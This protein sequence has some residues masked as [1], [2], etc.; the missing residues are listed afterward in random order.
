MA[1]LVF[2]AHSRSP[3]SDD[4]RD[5]LRD[6]LAVLEDKTQIRLFV[7]VQNLETGGLWH[8]EIGRALEEASVYV[9]LA[10]VE[11][12]A[13][14]SYF[15][16]NEWAAIRRRVEGG[17]AKVIWCAVNVPLGE[18][19][20]SLPKLAEY[21][22]AMPTPLWEWNRSSSI[23]EDIREFADALT[24]EVRINAQAVRIDSQKKQE[25]SSSA[26]P[27]GLGAKSRALDARSQ[28]DMSRAYRDYL[29]A[30]LQYEQTPMAGRGETKSLELRKL[31]VSLV[32]D[33]TTVDERKKAKQLETLQQ[34]AAKP[35]DGS[36][37]DLLKPVDSTAVERIRQMRESAAPPPER[38]T[39]ANSANGRAHEEADGESLHDILRRE[40]CCVILGDPGSGKSVLCKWLTLELLRCRSAELDNSD[41][42]GPVR[43]PFL[44]VLRDFEAKMEKQEV[45][46]LTG[47]LKTEQRPPRIRRDDWAAFVDHTFESGCAFL[48]L[49]GLD[50][51]SGTAKMNV[52]RLVEDLSYEWIESR[53][54]AEGRPDS[55][56]GNQMV[57]TSRIT[58]YYQ[59]ALHTERFAHYLIRPMSKVQIT[60][61]CH[62][63]CRES[64]KEKAID[65]L[66]SQIFDVRR[67]SVL[68]MARNP[69]LLSILCQLVIDHPRLGSRLAGSD[70]VSQPQTMSLPEIRA[71]LYECVV[72]E[73]AA[74]WRKRTQKPND[75]EEAF[76]GPI[77]GDIETVLALYAPIAGYMHRETINNEIDFETLK[78]Q[79]MLSLSALQGME[80]Q[81]MPGPVRYSREEALVEAMQR[82]V[83]VLSERARGRF[84]FLHLTFQEYLAG[85]ALLLRDGSPQI[86][87]RYRST[88]ELC[89]FLIKEQY[90][91]D[92]RWRQPLLLLLGQL[93]WF[94]DQGRSSGIHPLPRLTEVIEG[95]ESKRSQDESVLLVEQWAMFLADVVAE[96]PDRLLNDEE[97]MRPI[98]EQTVRQL[99]GAYSRLGP[100]ESRGRVRRVFSDRLAVIRRRVGVEDF[101]QLLFDACRSAGP[102]ST[103][104]H[105]ASAHLCLERF[106]ISEA[107]ILFFAEQKDHD[108]AH[109]E[110]VIHRL[111]RQTL[112]KE[113][114]LNVPQLPAKFDPPPA[115]ALK[116]TRLF[117]QALPEWER[118]KAEH[119]ERASPDTLEKAALA[120]PPALPELLE[121]I[122]L[123]Q[124]T[125]PADQ[126]LITLAALGGLG[127]HDSRNR[128]AK[129]REYATW[130]QKEDAER[131]SSLQAEPWRYAPRFG[132]DDTVYGMAVHLDTVGKKCYQPRF[133]PTFLP[134]RSIQRAGLGMLVGQALKA[135]KSLTV[136][137]Q[138][139]HRSAGDNHAKAE[140]V[141]IGR[142]VGYEPLASRP[143]DQGRLLWH[144]QR[145]EDEASDACF[146]GQEI[147]RR[148]LLSIKENVSASDWQRAAHVFSKAHRRA[149]VI[150]LAKMDK[151]S[152]QEA[153]N[154]SERLNL[155]NEFA[156]AAENWG[157]VFVGDSDDK[158]YNFAVFLDTIPKIAEKDSHKLQVL[159]RALVRSST[160]KAL[161]LPLPDLI[162]LG[163]GSLSLPPLAFY[164][165]VVE[166]IGTVAARIRLDLAEGWVVQMLK[167]LRE[168]DPVANACFW[169]QAPAMAPDYDVGSISYVRGPLQ[170]WRQ[171]VTWLYVPGEAM[172][173]RLS[174]S[175]Y[176]KEGWLRTWSTLQ[177]TSDR[178]TLARD[179][180]SV[181]LIEDDDIAQ[182]MLSVVSSV[183]NQW[184]LE[185]C[186]LAVSIA[187]RV[188]PE[189]NSEWIGCALKQLETLDSLDWKLEIM[190]AIQPLIALQ[191]RTVIKETFD[192][193]GS[194]IP[195]SY[196][197]LI[198]GK[199]AAWLREWTKS[200]WPSDEG[201]RIALAACLLVACSAEEQMTLAPVGSENLATSHH[202]KQIAEALRRKNAAEAQAAIDRLLDIAG[203]GSLTLSDAAVT[204]MEAGFKD[205]NVA[206]ASGL[207]KLLPVL[208]R[209][210]AKAL[211]AIRKWKALT[212]SDSS[213]ENLPFVSLLRCH[214]SLWLAEMERRY[215][216][217]DVDALVTLITHGDDRS[218]ERAR[219]ALHGPQTSLDGRRLEL[220]SL[221]KL[222]AHGVQRTMERIGEIAKMQETK[223]RS[224]AVARYAGRAW[225]IDSPDILSGWLKELSLENKVESLLRTV[226][227]PWRWSKECL[228]LVEEWVKTNPTNLCKTEYAEWLG[229]LWLLVSSHAD[230][231]L[232]DKDRAAKPPR[233]PLE[234][235][236]P[237]EWLPK[238]GC[239]YV[240][241]ECLG[242]SYRAGMSIDDMMA[243][244]GRA[245]E[246]RVTRLRDAY[247]ESNP[248]LEAIYASLGDA[249]TQWVGETPEEP[250]DKCSVGTLADHLILPLMKWTKH[251][252][253][254]WDQSRDKD[255]Q[256]SDSNTRLITEHMCISQV[257]ILAI[258][259]SITP[260]AIRHASLQMSTNHET[261]WGVLLCNVIRYFQN[262]R[263]VQAA[264]TVLARVATPDM[265][266]P[267]L[268]ASL[269][270][271]M[272]DKPIIRERALSV[273]RSTDGMTLVLAAAA[274]EA[275]FDAAIAQWK[276]EP[277]GQTVLALARL[278]ALLA[279]SPG[280]PPKLRQRIQAELRT[281]SASADAHRPLSRMTGLG[282]HNAPFA[283]V[284]E[285]WLDLELQAV[286]A[287]LLAQLPSTLY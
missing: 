276:S 227:A 16:T 185:A 204:V 94:E 44:V 225:G 57:L 259:C 177:S 257:S 224:E 118:L 85:F 4:L 238:D 162:E 241:A 277:R 240:I 210:S 236:P 159:L 128:E 191:D 45:S 18:V 243:E 138:D 103:A 244:L 197:S 101:E 116:E 160:I 188:G 152:A 218:A 89:D 187:R 31:Y 220:F 201:T 284:T 280:V 107:V 179:A 49:D 67:P 287:D 268:W 93:A 55:G 70:L 76:L 123:V 275:Q 37:K 74:N 53:S 221:A 169:F 73:T 131:Q 137:L 186:L 195:E 228:N 256:R 146:R 267:M 265:P 6:R 58:G 62:H 222:S 12:L 230:W 71:A 263:I 154:D 20:R 184:A 27:Q 199:E 126:L 163:A 7:D 141:A 84:A 157:E 254:Q 151:D 56:S 113:P 205:S 9:I 144:L 19:K 248:N 11:L 279:Q 202:W 264:W 135:G 252:L 82:E 80:P 108:S 10:S 274:S 166:L 281:L 164:Q 250:G 226:F 219:L 212:H 88:E 5:A 79:L 68:S 124:L 149:G 237:L 183:E 214:A 180:V 286:D 81:H 270:C 66:L 114:L 77:F 209:P 145:I 26:G 2:L 223:E 172:D 198:H 39:D 102:A 41:V 50:E 59:T 233:W 24:S 211:S 266:V 251:T 120:L 36:W 86:G 54:N 95:L 140:V 69:L 122:P 245:I 203:M 60:E 208:E 34:Q 3:E 285:G 168:V 247:S 125:E 65:D 64:G 271:S 215:D 23:T 229:V 282:D 17:K 30:R 8:Q 167:S 98:L 143:S 119:A 43:Q 217:A 232:A 14:S 90:L 175:L 216:S 156:D 213:L 97:S 133:L 153:G 194:S 22:A 272:R 182:R 239:D 190:A 121:P 171:V 207:R 72:Y 129:Y 115:E 148:W 35:A 33:P 173:E 273:L 246:S 155:V 29:G 134:P 253:H 234:Q 260:N 132:C 32:A 262:D 150:Q 231:K 181:D 196:Q 105:C 158:V 87:G 48:I 111:L 78:A 25:S 192:N 112:T 161:N 193:L 189:H 1:P 283:V 130:L 96:V 99:L 176:L 100:G 269:R 261:G 170:D 109:W 200:H 136:A 106:W 206:D 40:R 142:I 165:A 249:V 147:V 92:P 38:K 242:R 178:L 52:R 258:L 51:V 75:Q 13:P 117:H 28:A 139:R 42:L 127:D 15:R 63:F 47:Y 83:G 46:S 61:F 278:F 235:V 21:Q 104:I 110:W 174:S 91:T 255:G